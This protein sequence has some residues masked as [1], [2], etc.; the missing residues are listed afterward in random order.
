MNANYAEIIRVD[1][2]E[3]DFQQVSFVHFFWNVHTIVV[4]HQKFIFSK[5]KQ[6]IFS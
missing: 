5:E 3:L 2:L 6:K 1:D 4:N